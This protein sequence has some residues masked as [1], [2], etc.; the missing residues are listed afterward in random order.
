MGLLVS[1]SGKTNSPTPS[2]T[3]SYNQQQTERLYGSWKFTYTIINTYSDIYKLRTLK[4]S[5]VTPGDYYL[6]GVNGYNTPVI[7]GY[8]SQYKNFSLYDPGDYIDQFYTFNF[9]NTTAVSGCYYLIDNST[10]RMS[11][12]YSMYGN[13]YS[14]GTASIEGQNGLSKLQIQQQ[15]KATF[16]PGT[17]NTQ[18]RRQYEALK[19]LR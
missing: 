17:E 7:A 13:R 6:E 9:S 10:D 11:D 18:V 19:A 2:P 8:N 14:T 5:S 4:A 3:G 12:C 1:C 16:Q 15:L